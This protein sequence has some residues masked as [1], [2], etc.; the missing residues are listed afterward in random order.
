[1]KKRCTA[2]VILIAINLAICLALAIFLPDQVP[3]HFG[4][5]GAA[6]HTAGK[7]EVLALMAA[8]PAAIGTIWIAD[9][10]MNDSDNKQVKIKVGA[11][12]QVI[13]IGANLYLGLCV[14]SRD[15]ASLPAISQLC[16]A[17]VGIPLLV[18]GNYLPKTLP[19]SLVGISLPGGSANSPEAWRKTQRL[20]GY[21]TIA[22]G[23]SVLLC[24]VLL[25]GDTTFTTLWIVL[26]AWCAAC[27]IISRVVCKQ[28]RN[29]VCANEEEQPAACLPTQNPKE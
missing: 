15:H 29:R 4:A 3:V 2:I 25:T 11:L 18:L 27:G 13:L 6:D 1:M 21:V 8:I 9:T 19:G 5:D 10:R 14:L 28:E 17:S 12:V 24:G 7:Y 23:L 26:F 22:A 16:A 20:G